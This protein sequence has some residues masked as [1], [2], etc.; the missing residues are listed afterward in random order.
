MHHTYKQGF[1]CGLA[2]LAFIFILAA[3]SAPWVTANYTKGGS[4]IVTYGN[5]YEMCTATTTGSGADST[6]ETCT[7]AKDFCKELKPK[8]A[9]AAAFA[10]MTLLVVI[11]NITLLTSRVFCSGWMA[12]GRIKLY[13]LLSSGLVLFFLLIAF[14][15]TLSLK[16]VNSGDI[17]STPGSG[18]KDNY[19]Q[20]PS[21]PLMIFAWLL[22]IAAM[23]VDIFLKPEFADE[24]AAKVGL[25]NSAYGRGERKGADTE[26]E[27]ETPFVE[28]DPMNGSQQ[29]AY[30]NASNISTINTVYAP[31]PQQQQQQMMYAPPSAEAQYMAMNNMG[32]PM[33]AD[34]NMQMQMNVTYEQQHQM[35]PTEAG[36]GN[37][38]M[39]MH[40]ETT[41]SHH[42]SH[43]SSS[44]GHVEMQMHVETTSSHHESH[45]SSSTGHVEM[46]VESHQQKNADES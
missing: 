19:Q 45:S 10:I 28:S 11:F 39:Q 33:T 30:T 40:V 44:T 16:S 17:C 36:G 43:S 8:A 42:E 46:Q 20:G 29:I 4:T 23:G 6:S 18:A 22:W 41:S 38:Q 13:F 3:I 31:P 26:R 35:S 27:D 21:G 34:G 12:D 2:V 9:A 7:T 25:T 14:S 15:I 1:V 37:F 32:T 24:L 5:F